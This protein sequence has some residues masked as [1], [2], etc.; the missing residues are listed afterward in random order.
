MIRRALGVFLAIALVAIPATS[1]VAYPRPGIT[2]RVSVSSAGAEA[3]TELLPT[4]PNG[5]CGS[6][7]VDLSEDGRYV[8]FSH[9]AANLVDG[10]NNQV[11]DVFVHDRKTRRTDRVSVANGGDEATGA[12][13]ASRE[14]AF[15]NNLSI[16]ATGRYV[17]FV[18]CATNLV[19]GDTNLS[20]DVFVR[21]LKL[22][23]TKRVSL[24]SA[25]EPPVAEVPNSGLV[26]APSISDDGMQ[27]A[28][29]ARASGLIGGVDGEQIYVRDIK[30]QRTEIV[31][32]SATGEPAEGGFTGW[33]AIS[34][35]GRFVA[36]CSDAA[37][38]VSPDVNPGTFHYD[39]FVYDRKSKSPEL[40]SVASDET[41]HRS[42]PF[43]S[44][45]CGLES[46]SDDVISDDGRFVLFNS[47]GANLVPNDGNGENWATAL[48][49][50]QA[51]DFFV[52][53]RKT[54]RTE[55]V[56]VTS[57][58]AE[59]N[60]NSWPYAAISGNGR[61]VMFSSRTPFDETTSEGG[62]FVHDRHTGAIT[63]ISREPEGAPG[64]PEGE[65]GPTWD[66][67]GSF[68]FE[69]RYAAFTSRCW[70]L[71]DDDTNEAQDAFVRDIGPALGTGSFG[72]SPAKS[73]PGD[74]EI[75]IAP[76]LCVPPGTVVTSS[77][78]TDDLS[79]LL[80]GQGANLYGV[81]LVHRPQYEDLFVKIELEHMPKVVPGTS[82]IFYGLRFGF[83]DKTYEVRAASVL[84]GTFGL[85]DCTGPVTCTKVADLR[86]GYG[87]TG[88]RVVFSLPL[89]EIGLQNGGKMENVVAFSGIGNYL[90]GATKVLDSEDIEQR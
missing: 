26:E 82:P 41:Q 46:M 31:S 1:S 59:G 80:T 84:N 36:Y 39:V 77:D 68:S 4:S 56:S 3:R 43:L 57:T 13:P 53:D 32:R 71:V 66:Y 61:H 83:E 67:P 8:A 88:M 27:V 11:C 52:R 55:R 5:S 44:N 47:Y 35:D 24:S 86:G 6:R 64:C 42:Y 45:H 54:G 40:V 2:E 72:G 20:S 28:F 29:V 33:P 23:T 18:S 78:A 70:D 10:D 7:E 21:D 30:A 65:L 89:E 75:C 22:G 16:S 50:S 12:C 90:T 38:I 63:L 85:F 48:T 17:A 14:I 9:D 51:T 60:R 15:S 58:G 34:G 25:G 19:P 73:E 76:D 37:N 62:T 49:L 69:G 74:D 79:D 81:S 87:T